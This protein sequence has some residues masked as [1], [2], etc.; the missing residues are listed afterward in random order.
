MRGLKTSFGERAG[1]IESIG[2]SFC[3]SSLLKKQLPFLFFWNS[4][5]PGKPPWKLIILSTPR[6]SPW[7]RWPCSFSRGWPS[8]S[9]PA[10]KKAQTKT[11]SPHQRMNENIGEKRS[12]FDF[13]FSEFWVWGFRV[14]GFKGSGFKKT[15]AVRGEL[16]MS[17]DMWDPSIGFAAYMVFV[18]TGY[19]AHLLASGL[20][21]LKAALNPEIPWNSRGQSPAAL[22]PNP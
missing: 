10:A 2:V 21:S 7:L 6:G 19:I 20:K 1:Y 5:H 11:R 3:S 13:W 9:S 4:F 22:D 8:W 15:L 16:S 12:H 17:K 18:L 14:L